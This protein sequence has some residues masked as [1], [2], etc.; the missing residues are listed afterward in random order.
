MNYERMVISFLEG[1]LLGVLIGFSIA[2]IL[3]FGF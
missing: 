2:L 3:R 1:L